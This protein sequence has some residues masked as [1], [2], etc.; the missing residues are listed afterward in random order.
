MTKDLRVNNHSA[1]IL[2][3]TLTVGPDEASGLLNDYTANIDGTVSARN[4]VLLSDERFKNVIG[5]IDRKEAYDDVNKLKIIKYKFKDRPDDDRIY[6]GMI[7]QQVREIIKNAVDINTST[8]ETPE[9]IINIKDT[10][11][12]NYTTIISYLIS[13]L[14]YTNLKLNLLEEKIKLKL[15]I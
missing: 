14:Q 9:G 15:N 5:D 3:G 12:I 11:S 13:S 10:Y 6:T 2:G 8:Y 7:A 1:Y 4:I